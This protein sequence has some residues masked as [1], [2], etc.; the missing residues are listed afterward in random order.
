MIDR[1]T[2]LILAA[3]ALGIWANVAMQYGVK[4]VLNDMDLSNIEIGAIA[5][6]LH[7]IGSGKCDNAKLCGP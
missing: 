6:T 7:N 2:K 4:S 1:T 5:E 3:I